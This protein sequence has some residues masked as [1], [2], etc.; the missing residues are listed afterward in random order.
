[1]NIYILRGR[2]KVN[3]HFNHFITNILSNIYIYR[4]T[5]TLLIVTFEVNGVILR[6]NCEKLSLV[7]CREGENI[8]A[9]IAMPR[10]PEMCRPIKREQCL[11]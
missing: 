8:A 11:V 5:I 9:A 3:T 1:M 10:L 6:D 2:N 4:I 7:N